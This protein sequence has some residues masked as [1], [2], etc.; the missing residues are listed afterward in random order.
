MFH[1]RITIWQRTKVLPV[2]Y[3]THLKNNRDPCTSLAIF[4][5][6]IE[7]AIHTV[8]RTFTTRIGDRVE[9]HLPGFVQGSGINNGRQKK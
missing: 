3:I 7:N 2:F 9:L 1:A 5:F 8:L 6:Y 4:S